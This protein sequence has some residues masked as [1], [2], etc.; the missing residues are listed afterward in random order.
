MNKKLYFISAVIGLFLGCQDWAVAKDTIEV[1][2]ETVT[3][4]TET[5]IIEIIK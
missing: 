4:K 3:T 1:D 2:C 5:I